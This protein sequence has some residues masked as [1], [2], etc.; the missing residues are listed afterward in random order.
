MTSRIL[1]T[2]VATPPGLALAR[3]L[4]PQADVIAADADP[5]AP[6][7][8]I[9]GVTAHQLPAAADKKRYTEELLRL[10]SLEQPHALIPTTAQELPLLGRLAGR[11]QSMG[12]RTWLPSTRTAEACLDH[13]LLYT[14]LADRDVPTPRWWPAE[15]T[16]DIPH[17]VE[18]EVVSTSDHTKPI[19]APIPCHSREQARMLCALLEPAAIQERLHGAEFTADCLVDNHGQASVILRH[20][21]AIQGGV[22]MVTSTFHDP[23]AAA[24]VEQALEAAGIRGPACVRGVIRTAPRPAVVITGIDAH[25][26]GFACATAA[27]ADYLGQFMGGL[28]GRPV[29]HGRLRYAPHVRLAQHH[30]LLSVHGAPA[31]TWN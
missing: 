30:A 5:H 11:L 20:R 27:G 22:S 4:L 7:L 24:V 9:P 26:C 15:R 29:D 25:I 18:V 28:F 6:G 10:C 21:H 16:A 14:L 23:R 3:A 31:R 12:V 1:V 19:F 2:G 8:H 13:R 17:G